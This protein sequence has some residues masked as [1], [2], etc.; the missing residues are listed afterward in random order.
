M[1]ARKRPTATRG[2][3]VRLRALS[4]PE[5]ARMLDREIP[6]H[7]AEQVRHGFW[8]PAHALEASRAEF[9]R[10]LPKGL[11]TPNY[12]FARLV[13]PRGRRV[14]ELWYIVRPRGGK[15]QVWVDWIRIEPRYRR[16][17]YATD[18]LRR[19][20]AIARGLGAD[21]V[22][23]GV[24]VENRAARALYRTL[25]YTPYRLHLVRRLRPRRSA[26]PAPGRL[27]D[28]SR[29][30]PRHRTPARPR[31]RTAR[32]PRAGR[33]TSTSSRSPSGSSSRGRRPARGGS[34]TPGTPSSEGP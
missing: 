12:R 30:G 19:L 15:P 32:S 34:R 3:R 11:R 28:R 29:S 26:R 7:A 5:L 22:S 20:E 27:T 25:G 17:G 1:R 4:A 18:A 33:R 21:R 24:L 16:R 9:A 23:L 13:D 8:D 2:A 10:L 14:G 31:S 6:R